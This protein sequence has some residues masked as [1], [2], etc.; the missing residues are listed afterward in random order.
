MG[1]VKRANKDKKDCL[2]CLGSMLADMLKN[3]KRCNYETAVVAEAFMALLEETTPKKDRP[4]IQAIRA[5]KELERLFLAKA[6]AMIARQWKVLNAVAPDRAR[7][8]QAAASSL[9][10]A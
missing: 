8:A 6:C 9:R 1:K 7:K 10:A 4:D 3:P 2:L 5:D